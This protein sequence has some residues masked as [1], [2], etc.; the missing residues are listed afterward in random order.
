MTR[1]ITGDD[2]LKF[3]AGHFPE[4]YSPIMGQRHYYD[5]LARLVNQVTNMRACQETASSSDRRGDYVAIEQT[6]LTV[7]GEVMADRIQDQSHIGDGSD[8]LT[9]DQWNELC[10]FRG[11]GYMNWVSPLLEPATAVIDEGIKR[12]ET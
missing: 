12:G 3:A 5:L 8:V 11:L 9:Q 6:L 7:I 4:P 2:L 1:R 10:A